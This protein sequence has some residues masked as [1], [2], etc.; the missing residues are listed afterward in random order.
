MDESII[1]KANTKK[2]LSE[3]IATRQRSLNFYSLCIILPDADI[4][5]RRHG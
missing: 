3:E 5:L 1:K 4:V 2:S